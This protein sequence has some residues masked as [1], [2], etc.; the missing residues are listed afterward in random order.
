MQIQ[1][2]AASRTLLLQQ[3]VA[4]TA[5]AATLSL[6]S[7]VPLEI[8][9]FG[10]CGA[11]PA[12]FLSDEP[13]STIGARVLPVPV[14]AEAVMAVEQA[15]SPARPM[16]LECL[17]HARHISSRDD[18]CFDNLPWRWSADLQAKRSAADRLSGQ[19]FPKDGHA[20]PYHLLLEAVR[21][22]C[23]ADVSHVVVE[24]ANLLGGL[25]LGGAL[26]LDPLDPLE[27]QEVADWP[28]ELCECAPDEA[29][30]LA[31]ALQSV[32]HVERGVWEAEAVP[33]RYMQERG[34][35]RL[36]ATPRRRAASAADDEAS[37]ADNADE[38]D[39]ADEDS[40]ATWTPPLPWEI[41][42]MDELDQMSVEEKAFSAV[43]AGLRL[44]LPR[45]REAT[46]ATLVELLEPLLDETVRNALRIRRALAAGEF[47]EATALRAAAPRRSAMLD[48]LR[49]ALAAER[50]GEAA[51]LATALR[52]ET[53]RRADVTQDE[54]SY[55]RFL[56]QDDWYAQQLAREREALLQKEREKDAAREADRDRS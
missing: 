15:L 37:E 48:E 1:M 27:P 8:V 11:S 19:G 51:R 22:D 47:A 13:A 45:A 52:T 42:S 24:Q 36:Y 32:V 23:R 29:L 55:D 3:L 18:G 14:P 53:A 56:D 5:A 38:A 21:H 46:D 44:R 41:G 17:L 9:G 34:K 2:T 26:L 31:L 20:S 16:M 30:G 35:L 10:R 4:S 33:A 50:Y 54:G 12:L 49:L 28:Q 6:S 39:E 43:A 40:G 25:V 7:C